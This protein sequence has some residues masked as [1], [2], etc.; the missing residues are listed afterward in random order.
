MN[1]GNVCTTLCSVVIFWSSMNYAQVDIPFNLDIRTD[2]AKEAYIDYILK[3]DKCNDK[4]VRKNN[5]YPINEWLISLP[6]VKQPRVISYLH[7]LAEYNCVLDKQTI[8]I[9]TLKN[10]NENKA[11]RV[12]EKEGWF[13]SPIYGH[14][15]FKKI[16]PSE[17]ALS[18]NDKKALNALIDINYLPFNGIAMD[19]ILR[20][21][22][23]KEK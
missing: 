8:L 23:I 21:L 1:F 4:K 17:I 14:S 10:F 2:E 5:P 13:N 18:E 11:L 15:H 16:D 9:S 19:E 22:T 12:L 6:R 3:F 7:H 20:K